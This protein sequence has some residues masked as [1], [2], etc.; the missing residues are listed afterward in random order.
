MCGIAG[1]HAPGG[2]ADPRVVAAM[3]A[4][5]VHR[6]PDGD[7]FF[8]AP[9]IALGMRRLAIID[10][11]G[12]HQPLFNESRDVVA[13][14]NGE[15]YNHADLRRGLEARGHRL[16]S[17][18][19]GEVIPHLFEEE[20]PGFVERLN[21]IFAI[22]LWDGRERAL[23]LF[24][25][26]FGV[27]PLYYAREGGR[28]AFASEV[29]ALLADE[30]IPRDVDP[31]AVDEFL[32]FRFVPSPR[33]ALRAVCKLRPATVLS[34]REDG[35]KETEYASDPPHPHR[36]DRAALVAEYREAFER[37]V[38]RQMMSDVPIGVMLSG[39]VD[40]GAVCA[41]MAKHVERGARVHRRVR[42]GRRGGRR[43][44]GGAPHGRPA[45]RRPPLGPDRRARV[46]GRAARVDAHG[47][48]ADRHDER[49]RRRVRGPA[50]APRGAGGPERPGG[51]R[52][53]GR[54]RPPSRRAAGRAAAPRARRPR[55]RAPP[56]PP[57]RARRAGPRPRRPGGTRRPGPPHGRLPRAHGLGQARALPPRA[58]RRARRR[59][60][61]RARRSSAC[62]RAPP[63]STR[64][65]RCSTWTR[66]C[67]CPTSCC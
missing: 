27:K 18:S 22:A 9:G 31:V 24:R 7:G 23:H 21:G 32:T 43:D 63:T 48:G 29:K 15:L 33:T 46:P 56:P 38:E 64:S 36:T 34:S 42:R 6:G 41:V 26:R 17:G 61:R 8:D 54:L 49:A 52:A 30:S 39:G 55:A 40:S 4:R 11:E 1:I 57:G 28:L 10:P 66:G 35:V 59:A 19:D 13:V 37:A 16:N 65:A 60:P 14:F 62:G 58:G 3:T 25:D 2:E 12:G 53:A 5:L 51:R 44:R 45:R 50:D 67:R 20:G 47:G